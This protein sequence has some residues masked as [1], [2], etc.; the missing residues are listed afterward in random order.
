MDVSQHALAEC[1]VRGAPGAMVLREVAG[2]CRAHRS[3]QGCPMDFLFVAAS[4]AFF[5]ASL[6]YVRGCDRL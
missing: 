3:S 6:A 1:K 5:A 2:T 4:V